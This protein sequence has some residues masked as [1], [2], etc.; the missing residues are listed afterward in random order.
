MED[1]ARAQEA[2]SR[3]CRTLRR[4]PACR[5]PSAMRWRAAVG[6]RG[7]ARQRP[8]IVQALSA[9]R[10]GAQRWAL[11]SLQFK[12]LWSTL[13]CTTPSASTGC[14]ESLGFF[15][16]GFALGF[17]EAGAAAS[18]CLGLSF[19]CFL[20]VQPMPPLRGIERYTWAQTSN[21]CG[22]RSWTGTIYDTPPMIGPQWDSAPLRASGAPCTARRE[23][24]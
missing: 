17:E 13:A 24:R 14:F 21:S 9:L 10:K 8:G 23:R 22:D 5:P 15:A 4:A 18:S 11:K 3:A 12:T 7:R 20:P 2:T 19:L 6:A 16:T 1:A